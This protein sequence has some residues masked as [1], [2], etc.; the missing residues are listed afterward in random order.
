MLFY[1]FFIYYLFFAIYFAI[2][3]NHIHIFFSILG[4]HPPKDVGKYLRESEYTSVRNLGNYQMSTD[5]AVLTCATILRYGIPLQELRTVDNYEA[6]SNIL[7]KDGSIPCQCIENTKK[8]NVKEYTESTIIRMRYLTLHQ[9]NLFK[10]LYTP[11]PLLTNLSNTIAYW[12]NIIPLNDINICSVPRITPHLLSFIFNS[13]DTTLYE[14]I[15]S[16]SCNP[17]DDSS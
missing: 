6:V 12:E 3:N 17:Q 8:K 10:S 14:L 11:I 2:Y 5:T 16:I 13:Q 9:P 4:D 1:L 7:R 15:D